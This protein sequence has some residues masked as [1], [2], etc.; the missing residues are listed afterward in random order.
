MPV[1]APPLRDLLDRAVAAGILSTDQAAAV[2]ALDARPAARRGAALAEVL[3]YVG[4][5]LER[6]R[7]R[8]EVPD[9]AIR[10][11]RDAAP[12]PRLR[13]RRPD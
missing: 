2:A 1:P 4:G 3:G 13:L 7:P 9:R 12:K 5:A 10:R 8:L 11:C 6:G